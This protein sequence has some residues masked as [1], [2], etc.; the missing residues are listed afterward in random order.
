MEINKE[1]SFL[2]RQKQSLPLEQKLE[3]TEKSIKEWYKHW[4]GDVC[5][6]FSGGKDSTVLLD[7]VRKIYP[8]VPAVFVDTG[9]EFPEI[10]EFV[11]TI[12]NVVWLKPEMNFRDVLNKYG[13]PVISKS[14]SDKIHD[15]R[16]STEHMRQMRL[17]GTQ[18]ER[19]PKKWLFMLK[20]PFKISDK[21]CNVI[22]KKPLRK[23]QDETNKK[24]F[25][26]MMASE[27]RQRQI[28][29]IKYGCNMFS[30]GNPTSN[31]LSIWLEQDIWEYIKKENLPVSK[32]YEM[33]YDRTGCMFCMFGLN[34]Q[35]HPNK[36]ELMKITHP[37]QYK[38]CMEKLGLEK[39]INFIEHKGRT[40][41]S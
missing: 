4:D 35:K 41:F 30:A 5:V 37:L 11:K 40:L 12:D 1:T 28:N 17:H 25:I 6:S 24:P 22:K 15:I 21:C 33:G 34:L 39:I 38:Y 3:I 2:L 36:F 29:Y 20:A 10:R 31:P 32:I 26:G 14:V 27:G 18:M 9:L 23:Y 13:Y 7:I 19:L 16:N 8:E